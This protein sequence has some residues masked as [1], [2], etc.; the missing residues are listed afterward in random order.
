MCFH[1]AAPL[2]FLLLYVSSLGLKQIFLW[3]ILCTRT[4]PTDR[5]FWAAFQSE[6]F[7]FHCIKNATKCLSNFNLHQGLQRFFKSSLRKWLHSLFRTVEQEDAQPQTLQMLNTG[8]NRS[9]FHNF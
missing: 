5:I 7:P 2:L 4:E 1:L 6:I 3:S 8:M 9:L